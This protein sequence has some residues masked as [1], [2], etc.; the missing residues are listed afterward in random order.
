LAFYECWVEEIALMISRNWLALERKE[1][2]IES[3]FIVFARNSLVITMIFTFALPLLLMRLTVC[4]EYLSE[5]GYLVALGLSIVL[6]FL[7]IEVPQ[8][9]TLCTGERRFSNHS[10]L[11]TQSA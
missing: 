8:L 11:Y 4:C 1:R 10:L 6:T 5:L 3:F 2:F 9:N 7:G